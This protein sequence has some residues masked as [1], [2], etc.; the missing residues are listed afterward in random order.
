M[1]VHP[2][3]AEISCFQSQFLTFQ[4]SKDPERIQFPNLTQK[5]FNCEGAAEIS[6]QLV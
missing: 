4:M 5:M 6:H 2:G 1:T 3:D